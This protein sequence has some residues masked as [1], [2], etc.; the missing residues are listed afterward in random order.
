MKINLEY[1][2]LGL[3]FVNIEIDNLKNKL[4]EFDDSFYNFLLIYI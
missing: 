1:E 4:E 3:Y 2:T